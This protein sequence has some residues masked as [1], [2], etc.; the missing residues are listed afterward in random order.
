[1]CSLDTAKAELA[2][3]VLYLNKAEA[4]DKICRSIQYGSKF[5][6]NGQPGAAQNVD[7]STS[8]D[9]KVFRLFKFVND[10]HAL[11]SLPAPQTPLPLILLGKFFDFSS[12]QSSEGTRLVIKHRIN[13]LWSLQDPQ[14]LTKAEHSIHGLEPQVVDSIPSIKYH[15]ESFHSK[16]DTQCSICLGEYEDKEILRVMPACLHSYHRCCIDSWLQKHSTCPI[17]RCSL[18]VTLETRATS[19]SASARQVHSSD[20]SE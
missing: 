14:Y 18:N 3:L 7:K 4:R 9:R 20:L 1:M 16:E 2:L 13:C 19:P 15:Q 11:I 5:L 12:L 10:L 6:S 8:L 17:C